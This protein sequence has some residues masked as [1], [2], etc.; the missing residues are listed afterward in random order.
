M[1]FAVTHGIAASVIFK[2]GTPFGGWLAA[3]IKTVELTYINYPFNYA[4][5]TKRVI[6]LDLI[7]QGIRFSA[8]LPDLADLLVW[9]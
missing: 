4:N 5:K 1:L 6:T 7:S 3:V 9:R 8:Q 2:K